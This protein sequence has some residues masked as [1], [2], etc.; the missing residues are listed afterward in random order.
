MSEVGGNYQ[1]T[2]GDFDLFKFIDAGV[3]IL[4][5]PIYER[6][7][8]DNTMGFPEWSTNSSGSYEHG[9]CIW[10]Q[11]NLFSSQEDKRYKLHIS[12]K[13]EFIGAAVTKFQEFLSGKNG[14]TQTHLFNN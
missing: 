14:K 12:V 9:S 7:P 5:N 11:P 3:V 10:P 4:N 13:K 6:S 1:D 2:G 8:I